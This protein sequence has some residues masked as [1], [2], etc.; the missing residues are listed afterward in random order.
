MK[1][2][3]LFLYLKSKKTVLLEIATKSK[4]YLIN[5]YITI[6]LNTWLNKRITIMNITFNITLKPYQM[7]KN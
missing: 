5:E 4:F 1:E 2:K 6:G 3:A 7:L